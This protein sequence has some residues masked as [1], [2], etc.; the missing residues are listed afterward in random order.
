MA[1]NLTVMTGPLYKTEHSWRIFEKVFARYDVINSVLSLGRHQSWRRDLVRHLPADLSGDV[2]DVATGTGDVLLALLRQRPGIHRAWGVDLSANMLKVAQGKAERSS[3]KNVAW[4]KANA[5]QLPFPDN[6]F[7]AAT[8]A[9]GIRNI[10]RPVDALREVLRTLRPGG[11]LMILE[12]SLPRNAWTRFCALSY[13]R[14]GV[15]V[16]GGCLSG[17]FSA[18]RYLRQTIETF[19]CGAQFADLLQAAGFQ[20]PC[21]TTRMLGVV[22]LYQAVKKG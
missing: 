17:D 4:I 21:W 10:A 15:P 8:M 5:L 9:F 2:L 13:L 12:F 11:T 16:L 1:P 14:L 6:H 20:E 3:S 18:F 22:T 19:P 7:S